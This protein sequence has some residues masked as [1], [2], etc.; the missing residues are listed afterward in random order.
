MT[1]SSTPDIEDGDGRIRSALQGAADE[2]RRRRRLVRWALVGLAGA[3][4]LVGLLL[5]DAG[6]LP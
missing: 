5:L 1:R 2:A 4:P 3:L 6:A